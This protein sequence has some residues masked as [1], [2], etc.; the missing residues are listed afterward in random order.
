MKDFNDFCEFLNDNKEIV[1]FDTMNSLK[2][3][4]ESQQTISGEESLFI[5]KY[6]L[7]STIAIL[8][9][10]HKWLHEKPLA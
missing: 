7:K 3:V 8:R 1:L 2:D 10:Y 6:V 4:S 9:Q 5:E